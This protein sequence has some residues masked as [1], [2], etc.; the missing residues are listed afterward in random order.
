[1][2]KKNLFNIEFP[3]ALSIINMELRDYYSHIKILCDDEE[4]DYIALCNFFSRNGYE[5]SEKINQFILK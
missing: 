2:L 4:I 3:I 5:Y 1:M